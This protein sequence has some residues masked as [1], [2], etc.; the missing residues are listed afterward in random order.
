MRDRASENQRTRA[1]ADRADVHGL[2]TLRTL[3][4]F[5]FHL[6]ALDQT[7]ES[8]PLNRA[9]MTENVFTPA[10]LSNKAKALRI[11]KPLHSTSCHLSL[12]FFRF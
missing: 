4:R 9:V 6:L 5:E 11:V 1:L 7:T 2:Q 10:I 12:F 8:A 3:G